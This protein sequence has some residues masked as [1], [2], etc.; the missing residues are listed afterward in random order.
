MKP[1]TVIGI[2][3]IYNF[4]KGD[5]NIE[6]FQALNLLQAKAISTTYIT[7]RLLESVLYP[8]AQAMQDAGI[9]L[10]K[11]LCF[12]TENAEHNG[13]QEEWYPIKDIL[14]YNL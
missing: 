5:N 9:D 12:L 7:D 2:D 6:Q 8:I 13:Q 11:K 4:Y 1:K 10:N 3:I 14:S